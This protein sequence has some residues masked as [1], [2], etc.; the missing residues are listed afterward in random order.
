VVLETVSQYLWRLSL[1]AE[2]ARTSDCADKNDLTGL[3]DGSD[4]ANSSLY[5]FSHV[6]TSI[7]TGMT[8]S[9]YDEEPTDRP[10]QR[11]AGLFIHAKKRQSWANSRHKHGDCIGK[12]VLYSFNTFLM[13]IDSLPVKGENKQ[14]IL[15]GFLAILDPHLSDQSVIRCIRCSV[16]EARKKQ[17][18]EEAQGAQHHM[19]ASLYRIVL[20]KTVIYFDG[21]VR[22]A[23]YALMLGNCSEVSIT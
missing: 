11:H 3:T 1:H 7:C 14:Q 20:Q 5:P 16:T 9:T 22:D 21:I 15:V 13:E 2:S 8:P 23:R 17:A 19:C 4:V 10:S 6:M 18:C 12:G